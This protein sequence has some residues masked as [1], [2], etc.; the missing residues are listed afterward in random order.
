VTALGASSA[1]ESMRDNASF[2]M[3]AELAF[4]MDRAGSALSAVAR[5]FE[6]GGE[7]RLHGAMAHG[8][9]GPATAMDGSAS[10]RAGG[11]HG[12]SGRAIERQQLYVHAA[13]TSVPAGYGTRALIISAG[14]GWSQPRRLNS[15]ISN[16]CA[17]R[18]ARRLV[19][20]RKA[21][22]RLAST[23]AAPPRPPHGCNQVFR[24]R[25]LLRRIRQTL[26]APCPA[27][28]QAPSPPPS[29]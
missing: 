17:S 28:R 10:R 14:S 26:F 12:D 4:D 2:E 23:T 29:S 7:V 3:A 1:G 15:S 13:V 24:L 9:L 16:P 25:K 5:E 6:L 21:R 22:P 8:A 11:G 20:L 18:V 19:N 27:T